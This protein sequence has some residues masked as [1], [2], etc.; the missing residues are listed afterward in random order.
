MTQ[1][2]RASA[3]WAYGGQAVTALARTALVLKVYAI[4]MSRPALT[5]HFRNLET[6][7]NLERAAAALGVS[8]DE[9]AEAAIERELAAV[10]A[11]LEGK[12]ARSLERLK[13]YGAADLDR[14]IRAFARSEVEVEDPLQVRRVESSDAYGI[15]A[16][17]G[18]SME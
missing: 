18:D 3:A 7:R 15:G 9:L 2:R 17:F 13:S 16:L 10:G 11:G 4:A 6:L 5:L 1:N 12:L 8:M 14:D